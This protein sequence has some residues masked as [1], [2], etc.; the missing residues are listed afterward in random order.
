MPI[1]IS[2]QTGEIISA[3]EYTQDQKDKVWENIVREWVKKEPGVDK[4]SNERRQEGKLD[5]TDKAVTLRMHT[6]AD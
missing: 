1:K 5:Y 2:R 4:A 3:T 6:H